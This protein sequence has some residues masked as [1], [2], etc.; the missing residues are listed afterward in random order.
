MGK[1]AKW[2]SF[3]KEQIQEI[4]KQSRSNREVA[5]ALGYAPDGGG[6]MKSLKSMYEELNI[7]TSHFLGQSWNKENHDYSSF[8][9]NSNKKNGKTTLAPLVAL[10]GHRC[11]KCGRE[12][13]EGEKIPLHIHHKDGDHYNNEL[14]NLQLLCLNCHA[15][16]ENFC[17]K[18]KEKK[19]VPEEN[20]IL[21]LTTHSSIHSALKSLGLNPTSG[22]YV[23]A[24][25]LMIKNNIG[26]NEDN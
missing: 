26:F 1:I 4:V 13:W 6:T 25:E 17:T 22:N 21:A 8:T 5:I 9:K 19:I 24:K 20:F 18:K 23:R 3:S 11:E 7:D 16:T 12:E 15:L 2:R 10:R 14:D